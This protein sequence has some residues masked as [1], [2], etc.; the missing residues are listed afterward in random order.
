MGLGK[1]GKGAY[2]FNSHDRW[3]GNK[4]SGFDVW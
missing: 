2:H 3:V 1:E 4:G